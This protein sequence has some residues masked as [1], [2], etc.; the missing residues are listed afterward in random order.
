MHNR[1]LLLACLA[2][3]CNG[4]P[5]HPSKKSMSFDELPQSSAE[6]RSTG[7]PDKLKGLAGILLAFT[8]APGDKVAVVGA[9]G[10]VGRLAVQQLVEQGYTARVL[11]RDAVFDKASGSSSSVPTADSD[12]ES[13]AAWYASNPAGVEKVK[14][15]VT[16]R[17][18]LDD[19]LAG[20]SAVLA[21]HGATRTRK[22]SDFWSDPED[23]PQHSKYVN[24]EGVR[25]LI[26]AARAS[27]CC[28]RILRLTGKGETPYTFP[29]VL[30]NGFGSMAKAWNYEGETLLRECKDLEYTIVR[31][32]VMTGKESDFPKSSL[33]LADN[34]GNLEVTSIPHSSIAKLCVES[35][36][37]PNVGRSTLCAMATEEPGTGSDDWKT[38]LQKVDSDRRKFPATLMEEH[39][40][41]VQLAAG[42]AAVSF[43]GFLLFA[44]ALAAIVL[45]SQGKLDIAEDPF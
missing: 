36:A 24:Y 7:K 1:V 31:P 16:D 26:N 8:A 33:A 5:L 17:K 42:G 9:T 37:Y 38:L 11:L 34:G 28:K 3:V 44:G 4:R 22:L 14:G 12:T 21:V 30:I 32:G 13:V 18:S 43:F 45:G 25:N 35:L 6:V 2:C 40:K 23:D 20:C 27:G 41:A 15:D 29:S 19:L 10:K 39:E